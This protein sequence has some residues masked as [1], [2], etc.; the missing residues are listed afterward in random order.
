MKIVLNFNTNKFCFFS[1]EKSQFT[2]SSRFLINLQVSA[3]DIEETF[4]FKNKHKWG[5]HKAMILFWMKKIHL[6]FFLGIFAEIQEYGGKLHS[7]NGKRKTVSSISLVMCSRLS[8]KEIQK[9]KFNFLCYEVTKDDI[10]ER[11]IFHEHRDNRVFSFIRC[12]LVLYFYTD[13]ISL[14]A[15]S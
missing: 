12:P 3:K 11:K 2:D 10:E 5:N 8:Y 1:T 7:D 15:M 13:I 9:V 14:K 6:F 4:L